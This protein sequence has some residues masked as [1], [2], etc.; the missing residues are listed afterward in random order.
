[1][2]FLDNATLDRGFNETAQL[3]ADGCVKATIHDAEAVGRTNERVCVFSKEIALP[4][5]NL[6]ELYEGIRPRPN[7]RLP[8]VDQSD[9]RRQF[10]SCPSPSAQ[11]KILPQA[12]H[13]ELLENGCG[14]QAAL[15][16]TRG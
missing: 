12:C 14:A 7:E 4:H 15:A 9:L 1:M 13:T 2:M 11:R 8:K 16:A 10:S 3:R 6:V 5:F